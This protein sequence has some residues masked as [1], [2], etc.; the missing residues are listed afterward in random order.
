MSATIHYTQCPVCGSTAIAPLLSAKD[1]TVSHELFAIW[2]CSSCTHR[3]TQDIPDEGNIGR[4]YKSDDYISHSNTR[5][6]LVNKLYLF[7]RK[8][9]LKAKQQLVSKTTGLK[10]GA[11][12]D[13]G[14]G[15]G[16]FALQMQ[17]A[18]W[19]VTGLEPDGDA[20]RN[21]QDLHNI[22]LL[23]TEQLFQLPAAGF[24]AITLWHVLEHVQQLHDYMARFNDLL[25]KDG[26]LLIAVP[27]YT[28]L[29][30]G[31]YKEHWAAYD[32]PRHLY[33][34]SPGSMQA[35][36][37]RHGFAIDQYIP[38]WFDSFY[39]SMLSE[40]YKTG[41]IRYL[42]AFVNGLRSNLKAYGKPQRYSSVI[43]VLKKK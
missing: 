23:P 28:S 21:A 36:A 12:L 15:T 22:E 42:Q 40:Q 37:Q 20:R 32:V 24:D 25:R 30:A 2:Q 10:Q 41:S 18:G 35:L 3:F 13:V 8:V 19:Q 34:F 17:Q 9:T 33:H 27:N 6:G 29:D 4:Y 38:M 26:V 1:N 7:I 43:Y 39:I 31:I 5:K 16:A 11:L 14:A